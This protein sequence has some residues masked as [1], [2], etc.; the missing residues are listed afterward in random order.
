ML[1]FQILIPER[2]NPAATSS[3]AADRHVDVTRGVVGISKASDNLLSGG[4]SVKRRLFGWRPAS[5]ARAACRSSPAISPAA[6]IA[7]DD[8]AHR[9]AGLKQGP[10]LAALHRGRCSAAPAFRSSF[11]TRTAVS[12]SLIRHGV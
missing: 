8:A 3:V 1:S 12:G 5:R 4:S 9:S 11:V 10:A 6:F 2:D 7:V